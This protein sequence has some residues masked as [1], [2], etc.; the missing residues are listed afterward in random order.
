MPHGLVHIQ[1]S[2]NNTI[3]TITDQEG[4]VICPGRARVRSASADRARARPS[5]R[6]RLR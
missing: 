4:N 2:F 6:S 1:A 5:P 3:V